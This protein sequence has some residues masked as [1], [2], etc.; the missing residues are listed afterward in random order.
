MN[1]GRD[2]TRRASRNDLVLE[3]VFRLTIQFI[4]ELIDSL[5]LVRNLTGGIPQQTSH[6]LRDE[7]RAIPCYA[8]D[9]LGELV[10]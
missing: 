3:D 5:D 7:S 2:T 10:R 8:V 1:G 9:L 6:R 4:R